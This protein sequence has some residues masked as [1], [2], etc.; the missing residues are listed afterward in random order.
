MGKLINFRLINEL[1]SKGLGDLIVKVDGQEYETIKS[2][3]CG[4]NSTLLSLVNDDKFNGKLELYDGCNE[5][6][7]KCLEKYYGYRIVDINQSN[8]IDILSICMY[9]DEYNL[10][11]ECVRYIKQHINDE[12]ITLLLS[13]KEIL[14]SDYL[15][16]IHN[17]TNEYIKK[18]SYKILNKKKYS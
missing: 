9:Y 17:S 18:N 5:N 8:V 12:M 1:I 13:K 11:K 10:L 15:K 14:K 16:D 3:F 4:S 7:F 6:G 2:I